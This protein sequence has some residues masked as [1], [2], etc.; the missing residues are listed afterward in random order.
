MN[1]IKRRRARMAFTATLMGGLLAVA[2]SG[3]AEAVSY[4]DVKSQPLQRIVTTNTS[5]ALQSN[6]YDTGADGGWSGNDNY[7]L[8]NPGAYVNST[9]VPWV[10]P[11][12]NEN[13]DQQGW[14]F[15]PSAPTSVQKMSGGTSVPITV[16]TFKIVQGGAEVWHDNYHATWGTRCLDVAN[17]WAGAPVVTNPC[18]DN[19]L[20]QR[21]IKITDVLGGNYQLINVAA[22]NF[23]EGTSSRLLDNGLRLSL[24]NVGN[25]GGG[26]IV[27]E[28]AR[29]QRPSL[30]TQTQI[31]HSEDTGETSL[32]LQYVEP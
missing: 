9:N 30:G 29:L 10:N 15:V 26:T 31:F 21:W 27:G 14:V 20:T 25:G 4:D 18:D 3:V 7:Q 22:L 19:M 13:L 24:P 12:D 5:L 32:T 6:W 2:T 28:I 1:G 8:P 11:R 16:N 17:M 23:D